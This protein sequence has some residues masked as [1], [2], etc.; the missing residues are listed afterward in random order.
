MA[1]SELWGWIWVI[2]VVYEQLSVKHEWKGPKTGPG[3]K[4]G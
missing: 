1:E 4:D 2:G 3:V